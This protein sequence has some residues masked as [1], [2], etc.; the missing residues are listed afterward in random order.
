MNLTKETLRLYW[1]H[2]SRYPRYVTAL[3]IVVPSTLLVHQFLPPLIVA[4]VLSRL[5]SGDYVKGDLWGSFGSTL[6]LYAGLA[7]FASIVAW[8]VVNFFVW[9]L[10]ANVQRDLA[11][12][13][14]DHLMQQSASFHANRFG[15]SLVSQTTKLLSAYIRIADTTIYQIITLL[16]ALTFTAVILASRAPAFVAG[17]VGFTV[18]FIVVAFYITKPVRRA[19]AKL[20]DA[21]SIQTGGLAD[22]IT[23]VM[24][25]KSFAGN[26][27][28]NKRFAKATEVT[29]AETL[30]AMRANL[31][32]EVYFSVMTT[33]T[34][35]LALIMAAA[36]VVL[37]NADIATT[38]LIL[39]YTANISQR[40]WDF[41]TST[42]RNYNQA[43]GDAQDMVKILQIEPDIKDIAQPEK[44]HISHGAIDFADV[45]FAHDGAGDALFHN[46]NISIRPGEKVGLVGQS[47]SGKTTFTRLLLRFSDIDGGKILIDGQSIAR[48]AQE[49]L[50]RNIAYVPQEPIMFH[51]SIRENI[52]YGKPGATQAQIVAAA[53]KAHADD[54]IKTLPEGYETLVGE[55]GI[56]LSGGQRQRIAIARA[57]LKDAPILVLDEATSALDSESEALIQDALREL[58]KRRTAIAIA[59]RLSTIQKMDRIIVLEDGR[60]AEEGTHA[61]LIKRKGIYAKLWAHQSGG[62]IEE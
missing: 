29:R 59:H 15:G 20:A 44:S 33:S 27:Y 56:K 48:I 25:V 5:S 39:S 12:R 13:V 18:V 40:L 1:H 37:F 16:S 32:S 9:K 11:Q 7:Y 22:S 4:H 41:S 17:L 47:G 54:F 42:L 2:A 50:R 35:V 14:F 52:A 3:A 43:L 8:K 31:R 30:G 61:Q 38:F 57:I 24:A 21:Q 60:V 10:E 34:G 58:M 45:T 46:L 36:S 28:E 62:F 19:H 49:D 53:K 55:R 26:Q 23:N 51:R 6:L